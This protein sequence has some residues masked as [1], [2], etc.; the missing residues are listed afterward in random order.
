MLYDEKQLPELRYLKHFHDDESPNFNY[1]QSILDKSLSSYMFQNNVMF[2]FL[3]KLK[4]M[5]ALFFDQMNI[6]KNWRNY[7]VDKYHYKQKG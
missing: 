2:R 3:N 4:L 7:M 6:I 1:E 5:L